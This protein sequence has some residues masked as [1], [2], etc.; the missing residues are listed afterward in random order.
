VRAVR[1]RTTTDTKIV[2]NR[3]TAVFWL[4]IRNALGMC[5]RH[6][7]FAVWSFLYSDSELFITGNDRFCNSILVK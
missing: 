1:G 3:E 4:N 6:F 5:T 2:R 7:C